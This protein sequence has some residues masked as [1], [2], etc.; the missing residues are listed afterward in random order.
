MLARIANMVPRFK[1]WRPVLLEKHFELSLDDLLKWLISENNEG[2][3]G[4]EIPIAPKTDEPIVLRGAIDRVDEDV[5]DLDSTRR[6]A[7]IIDYKTGS[8]P[9]PKDV[10]ELKDL[11]I[12]LYAVALEVGAVKDSGPMDWLTGEGFY[13]EVGE[14]SSGLPKTPHLPS[15]D[16]DGRS[17]LIEGALALVNLA[18]AAADPDQE[19]GLIPEEIKG[20]G[21][22]ELPCRYCE[23]RGVCRLEDRTT[24]EP[25][26]LKVDKL[27][28]RKEGA[29]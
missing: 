17:I 5:T 29:W 16:A 19:F 9:K 20:E 15:R 21:E 10:T 26:A 24:P 4:L 8:L 23:F 1:T 25:T 12:L 2:S 14:A 22:N 3:L 7:A 11:Q 18:I 13:Y 28:N 27:V 6:L